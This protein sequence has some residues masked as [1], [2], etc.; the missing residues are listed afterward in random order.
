MLIVLLVVV[1]ILVIFGVIFVFLVRER[2]RKEGIYFFVFIV[3]LF[4]LS[5]VFGEFVRRMCLVIEEI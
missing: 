5:V 4:I 3:V 1:I 2:G